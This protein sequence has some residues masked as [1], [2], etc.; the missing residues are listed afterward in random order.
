MPDNNTYGR[1]SDY[2]GYSAYS[3]SVIATL[4]FDGYISKWMMP[5]K[6]RKSLTEL[7]L[8]LTSY[9]SRREAQCLRITT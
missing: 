8:A 9:M 1:R 4:N 7:T 3:R 5:N 2:I 6:T